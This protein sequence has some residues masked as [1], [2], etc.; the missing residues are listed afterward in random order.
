MVCL[1]LKEENGPLGKAEGGHLCHF[2]LQGGS[3]NR[4]DVL[5]SPQGSCGSGIKICRGRL[6]GKDCKGLNIE[7]RERRTKAEGKNDNNPEE[8]LHRKQNGRVT[9]GFTEK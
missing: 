5:L 6:G 7:S 1:D 2:W 9:E 8:T 3:W 4:E